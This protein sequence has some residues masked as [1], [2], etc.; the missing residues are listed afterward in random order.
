MTACSFLFG[1]FNQLDGALLAVSSETG[2]TDN[3]VSLSI[4]R[5]IAAA[6]DI[7]TRMDMGSALSVKN[8]ASLYKLTVSSL[9]SE[10][11]RF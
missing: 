8:V 4:Q 10:S 1:C 6:A 2:V 11:L 7:G 9:C 5:I 3:T